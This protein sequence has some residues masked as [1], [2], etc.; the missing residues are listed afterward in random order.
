M[1]SKTFDCKKGRKGGGETSSAIIDY[2]VL[3]DLQVVFVCNK[4]KR[5]EIVG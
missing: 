4:R 1:A 5:G 3:W 2:Q